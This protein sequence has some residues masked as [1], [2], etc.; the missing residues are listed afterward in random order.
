MKCWP[1]IFATAGFVDE[2]MALARQITTPDIRAFVYDAAMDRPDKL[3]PAQVAEITKF[4]VSRQVAMTAHPVLR[5]LQDEDG[6]AKQ[7]SSEKVNA[8]LAELV[9]GYESE[10]DLPGELAR[11]L[12][13]QPE[14]PGGLHQM[15]DR[16]KEGGIAEKGV[17]TAFLCRRGGH[18]HPRG[19]RQPD[20][21]DARVGHRQ[22]A[23]GCGGRHPGSDQRGETTHQAAQGV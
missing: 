12:F 22:Q 4:H 14:E 5:K 21:G 9:K 15:D 1:A 3:K 6:Y 13:F 23:E 8:A 7:L 11:I 10:T 20:P 2:A 18:P 19:R 16:G 17:G